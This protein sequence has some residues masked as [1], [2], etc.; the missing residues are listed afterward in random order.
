MFF[1]VRTV[2]ENLPSW[3]RFGSFV[4]A[5]SDA[6]LSLRANPGSLESWIGGLILTPVGGA[7]V[8]FGALYYGM[9]EVCVEDC[10]QA[11][12][13]KKDARADAMSASLN[14]AQLCPAPRLAQQAPRHAEW[15]YRRG[16]NR[17][18]CGG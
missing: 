1:S 5:P 2:P 17:P 18:P 14:V 8:A 15:V 6:P 7:T 4:I 11:S 10:N 12:K 16:R 9:Q 13:E 3:T